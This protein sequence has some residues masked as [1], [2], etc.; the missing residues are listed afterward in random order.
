MPN[1]TTPTSTGGK[2]TAKSGVAFAHGKLPWEH[3]KMGHD[4][5]LLKKHLGHMCQACL[6]KPGT[7]HHQQT[8]KCL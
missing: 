7:R 2:I 1:S 8:E 3:Q 6:A 5:P 4:R